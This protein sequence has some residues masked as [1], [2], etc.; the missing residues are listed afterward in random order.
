MVCLVA[1]KTFFPQIG[2]MTKQLVQQGINGVSS[3]LVEGRTKIC[4]L[5]E[6]I[7]TLFRLMLRHI[8]TSISRFSLRDKVALRL[9]KHYVVE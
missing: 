2:H 1:K 8:Y 9:L 6:I 7:P 3:N 4:Q 5:Q